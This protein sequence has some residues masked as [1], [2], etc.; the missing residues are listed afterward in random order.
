[1]DSLEDRSWM[2]NISIC[3]ITINCLRIDR[4]GHFGIGERQ[5]GL[6]FAGEDDSVV[7]EAINQGF[8]ADSIAT[9]DQLAAGRVPNRQG[10]H[11]AQESKKTRP[12][13]FIQVNEDF[14]IAVRFEGV[15]FGFE[16]T[17]EGGKVIDFA[18][19]DGPNRA[20]LI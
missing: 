14:G 12:L 7:I 4:A 8:L 15:S 13:I 5:E 1:M 10:E 9:E 3:E 6:E 16:S 11:A 17:A 19:E 2:R 18:V 20:V